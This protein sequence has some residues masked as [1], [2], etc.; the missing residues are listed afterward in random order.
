[1]TAIVSFWV[2]C[3]IIAVLSIPLILK[4]VPPNRL[5]GFRTRQTLSNRSLWFR[6]NYFVG[7]ALLVAAAVSASIFLVA[8]EYASGSSAYGLVIFIVPIVIALLASIAYLRKSIAD[9][10]D[11]G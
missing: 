7:W 2:P 6:V 8:P 10:S 3:E 1:M 11:N 4:V 9:G 5:Y